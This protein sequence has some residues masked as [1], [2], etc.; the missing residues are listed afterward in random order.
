MRGRDKAQ[1]HLTLGADILAAGCCRAIAVVILRLPPQ[2]G[3]PAI[4]RAL[5]LSLSCLQKYD[6]FAL[7][8]T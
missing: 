3:I 6:A 7:C 8:S 2:D 1:M 4:V 5:C